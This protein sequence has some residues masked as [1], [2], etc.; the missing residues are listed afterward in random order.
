VNE[1]LRRD[2][3]NFTAEEYNARFVGGESPTDDDVSIT[4]DGRRIDTVEKLIAF[5]AEI[6]QQRLDEAPLGDDERAARHA[7]R[8]EERLAHGWDRR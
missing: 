4:W 7:A 8:E 3:G 6:E 1:I 5:A 2:L